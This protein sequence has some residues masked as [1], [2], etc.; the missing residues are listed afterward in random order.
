MLRLLRLLVWAAASVFAV[1]ALLAGA[2]FWLYRDATLPGPLARAKTLVI[3]PHSGLGGIAAQLA[4]DGVVRHALTF[5]ALAALTGHRHQ[6][7]PGEYAFPPA[8]SAAEALAIIVADHTVRH[9]LTI[10]EGLTSPQIVARV[11]AAP[12][13]TGDP[14]PM[15]AEGSLYP[16]TYIY[17]YGDSRRALIRHMRRAMAHVVALLWQQREPGLP[18]ASPEQAVA[19][20]SIIEK[21]TAVP[22]E[23]AH[24]AGVY[25]NRL[26]LGMRLD[27]DPTVLFALDDSGSKKLG[28]PLN[29]DDLA[30]ASPYNTYRVSGLPPGPIDN[31]GGA[32]LRAALAPAPTQDLYFVADG[33]GGHVFAKTL[34][35]QTRNIAV[36]LH[37]AALAAP[38]SDEQPPPAGASEPKPPP[39]PPP[40]PVIPGPAMHPAPQH[41]QH[42][43]VRHEAAIHEAKLRGAEGIVR[44]RP[45]CR[46]EPARPCRLP[47]R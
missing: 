3:P 29:H 18:L 25:I 46:A 33:S 23:R 38:A 43:A 10:P 30:V 39:V 19:L 35:E 31:P 40:K 44:L 7:H 27:A 42:A 13:L 37:G 2:T 16:D 32:A 4:R 28:R 21:E 15:P 36:Y 20:A 47:R 12:A 8:A 41:P 45:P 11:A 26:R 24:V 34:A 14:G 5:E 17:R 9:K 22:A 1:A 6:L